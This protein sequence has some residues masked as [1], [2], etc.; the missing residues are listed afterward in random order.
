MTSPPPS[1]PPELDAAEMHRRIS[2]LE[3]EMFGLVEQ[4][5]Q[6]GGVA[7]RT[8]A[9]LDDIEGVLTDLSLAVAENTDALQPTNLPAGGPVDLVAAMHLRQ[10][11]LD[12]DD[13]P[14]AP[15]RPAPSASEAE[16]SRPDLGALHDWVD[17]HVAPLVRKT[18]TT[19]EGGGVRWCRRWWEHGDA[20]D[21]FT[22]LFLTFGQLSV[23]GEPTWLSVYLRDHLDPHLATLTS[24][25]GPFY[26][27]SPR[28]H[29]AAIE[30]LGHDALD[31][32]ASASAATPAVV[33]G[34]PAGG[35]A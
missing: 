34:M 14:P 33:G 28:K 1:S 25:Y 21:R 5:R 22:A 7:D 12:T 2:A 31:A 30:P 23:S 16:G 20:V 18:T 8:A 11:Q 6:V 10:T 4:L 9:G 17:T 24:P 32:S 26:A 3:T 27:C 13:P 35:P 15:T 19:G 29:S